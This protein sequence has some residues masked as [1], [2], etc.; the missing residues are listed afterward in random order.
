MRRYVTQLLDDLTARRLARAE[1]LR[2]LGRLHEFELL[3]GYELDAPRP[4][5][6]SAPDAAGEPLDMDS[7]SDGDSDSADGVAPAHDYDEGDDTIAE[8][9]AFLASVPRNDAEWAYADGTDV[10]QRE[11]FGHRIGVDPRAFPTADSLSDAEVEALADALAPTLAAFG[12][13]YGGPSDYP[14]RLR[15]EAL[16]HMLRKPGHPTTGGMYVDDGCTG[17]PVG[18]RWGA[19]CGCLRFWTRAEFEQD[20]GDAEAIPPERFRADDAPQGFD[21]RSAGA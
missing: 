3:S 13:H 19:Y 5:R 15:Y 20:G 17:T 10:P 14:V 21:W 8:V 7:D 9:E 4:T 12:R 1:E 6:L 18:C 2:R 16:V 11:Q